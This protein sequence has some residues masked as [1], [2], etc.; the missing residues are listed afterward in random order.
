MT[1]YA[2]LT[3]MD[4][5]PQISSAMQATAARQLALYIGVDCFKTANTNVRPLENYF[6]EQQTQTH[7]EVAGK[8]QKVAR[9]FLR[10]K[11]SLV[12]AGR[13]SS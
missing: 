4:A 10:A 7:C 11:A 9:N 2:P 12:C 5:A 6:Y 8:A 3:L 13:I 1:D